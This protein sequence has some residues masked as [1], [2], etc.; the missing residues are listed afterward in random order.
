MGTLNKVTTNGE[1]YEL[2]D[3]RLNNSLSEI[4]G[5]VKS[6][7]GELNQ[8]IAGT[9]YGYPVIIGASA[10]TEETEGII[11]QCY[12][13]KRATKENGLTA[14]YVCTSKNQIED[15]MYTYTWIP[16]GTIGNVLNIVA[17][18]Y[19]PS[20]A[21]SIGDIVIYND[22]L[23]KCTVNIVVGEPWTSNHWVQVRVDNVIREVYDYIEREKAEI[24]NT[25]DGKAPLYTYGQEDMTDGITNLATGTLYF[26]YE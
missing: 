20:N 3:Y 5:L 11:G 17:D 22:F 15:N 6:Q 10:P 12:V 9:D 21:Y 24:N 7:H 16:I 13:D 8:A 25:I 19:S 4:N 18:T 2:E 23:Y 1:T 14:E 26:V